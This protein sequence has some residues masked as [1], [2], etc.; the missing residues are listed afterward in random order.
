MDITGQMD[1]VEV[2]AN[3]VLSLLEQELVLIKQ[4]N[5]AK[6]KAEEA[7]LLLSDLITAIQDT[8]PH[9]LPGIFIINGLLFDTTRK[10]GHIEI[11]KAPDLRNYLDAIPSS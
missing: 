7:R 1:S 4:A 2:I 8:T 10:D 9:A 11:H 3:E 6:E 5:E